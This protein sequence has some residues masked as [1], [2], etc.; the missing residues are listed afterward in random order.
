MSDPDVPVT[1]DQAI[2]LVG[3]CQDMCPEFE[4]VSRMVQKDVWGQEMVCNSSVLVG[5]SQMGIDLICYC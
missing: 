5:I 2:K 4:R 3:T 1:L